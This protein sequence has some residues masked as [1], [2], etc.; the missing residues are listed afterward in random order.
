MPFME[1]RCVL[2]RHDNLTK[3]E[4]DLGTRLDTALLTLSNRQ[5][6]VLQLLKF[7]G[8]SIAEA[9]ALIGCTLTQSRDPLHALIFRQRL[10][11]GAPPLGAWSRKG[12]V[13]M[14]LPKCQKC[15]NGLLIPLSDYGQ[16]GATV[17]FKAWVCTNPECGFS[18][19]VDKGDVTYG[20]KIEHKH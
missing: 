14:E 9:A 18:L 1:Q 6:E 15:N 20:K 5:C 8:L 11:Y 19:R 2:D 7:Q 13:E 17:V 16:E 4:S 3:I 12:G 10:R